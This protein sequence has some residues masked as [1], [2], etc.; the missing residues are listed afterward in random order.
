[1]P[2]RVR[3]RIR[4]RLSVDENV[5]ESIALVGSGFEADTPQILVPMKLAEVLG[6]YSRLLE[7][8]IE[9]YGIPAG[10]VRMYVLPS[11][12]EVWIVEDDVETNKV[13]CDAV[14]SNIEEEVLI[15]DYLAG[16]LEIIVEDLKNGVW[17]L[18]VDSP[19]E[20]RR[21]YSPQYWR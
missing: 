19:E 18:K 10:P 14:I 20:R 9:S 1:M 7:A 13:V 15:S 6:L 8:R 3:L 2:V 16:E 11:S 12:L 4:N 17:R 21:I 5:A